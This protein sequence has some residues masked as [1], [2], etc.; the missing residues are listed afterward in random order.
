MEK[1]HYIQPAIEVAALLVNQT[2]LSESNPFGYG[3][4]GNEPI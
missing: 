2:I 3:E 1:K 4:G